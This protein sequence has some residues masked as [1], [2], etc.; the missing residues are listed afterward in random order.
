VSNCSVVKRRTLSLRS[1]GT[2]RTSALRAL[3]GEPGRT[4]VKMFP[5]VDS[6]VERC[7]ARKWMERGFLPLAVAGRAVVPY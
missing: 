1:V 4:L 2:L 6:R 3:N 7:A 5:R